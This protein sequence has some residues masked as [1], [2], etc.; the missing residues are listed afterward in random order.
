MGMSF[1]PAGASSA[2]G[3]DEEGLLPG[4]E[5]PQEVL[6]W[7]VVFLYCRGRKGFTLRGSARFASGRTT[8]EERIG[9]ITDIKYFKV[10]D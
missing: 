7:I 1:L 3:F 5:E 9:A 6:D 4:S 10:I 2:S 8:P